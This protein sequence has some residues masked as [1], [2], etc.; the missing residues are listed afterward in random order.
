MPRNPNVH[1]NERVERLPGEARR[2]VRSILDDPEYQRQRIRF[3]LIEAAKDYAM[4]TFVS[5]FNIDDMAVHRAFER[6]RLA[7]VAAE[8]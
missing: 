3:E 5:R 4:I 6:L 7:I 2:D 8:G 1:Q